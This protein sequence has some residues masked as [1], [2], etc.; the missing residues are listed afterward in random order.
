MSADEIR[1]IKEEM[2][3]NHAELLMQIS[4]LKEQVDPISSIYTSAQGFG[5]V[6]SW[7]AKW[8]LTPMIVLLGAMLT[9]KNLK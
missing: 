8:V 4:L 1:T 6:I 3:K 2:Q 5:S 7:I 9:F